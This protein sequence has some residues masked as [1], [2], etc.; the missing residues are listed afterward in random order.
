MSVALDAGKNE[1][2]GKS[3]ELRKGAIKKPPLIF[4]L[5]LD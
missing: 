1:S 3:K 4:E 5:N 2:R